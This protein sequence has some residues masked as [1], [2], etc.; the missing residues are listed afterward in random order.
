MKSA[1]FLP[2]KPEPPKFIT[3]T[4]DWEDN[5]S[6]D[7][8]DKEEQIESINSSLP[9]SDRVLHGIKLAIRTNNLE[10]LKNLLLDASKDRYK[11]ALFIAVGWGKLEILEWLL[12]DIQGNLGELFL[13]GQNLLHFNKFDYLVAPLVALI[14]IDAVDDHDN[15]ALHFA[16][17][18]GA[19]ETVRQLLINGANPNIVNE[20]GDTALHEAV[21]EDKRQTAALLLEYGADIAVVNN[22]NQDIYSMADNENFEILQMADLM[23]GHLGYIPEDA[24]RMLNAVN[25]NNYGDLIIANAVL[26]LHPATEGAP[27]IAVVEPLLSE[28]LIFLLGAL[29][30]WPVT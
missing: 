27:E 3:T 16:A 10:V 7:N 8:M 26:F 13:G 2:I 17:R 11:M 29:L 28:H 25:I 14:D 9:P 30:I 12:K 22:Y 4:D 18:A 5:L 15:T 21:Q 19:I 20:D 6:P 23:L 1:E 24:Y